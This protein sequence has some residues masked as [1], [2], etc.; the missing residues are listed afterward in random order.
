MYHPTL[1]ILITKYKH[2]MRDSYSIFLLLQNITCR[3]DLKYVN[4]Y[5]NE[6]FEYIYPKCQGSLPFNSN[7]E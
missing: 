4:E 7:D 5:F 1:S 2:H 3:E 6:Y